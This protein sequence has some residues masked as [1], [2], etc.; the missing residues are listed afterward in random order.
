MSS[1][2]E[3]L[4]TDASISTSVAPCQGK[5]G[6]AIYDAQKS[7]KT[8]DQKS[9]IRQHLVKEASAEVDQEQDLTRKL[10]LKSLIKSSFSYP[11][12]KI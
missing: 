7:T 6:A 11:G 9:H 3:S 10:S 1:I 2:F 5:G 12:S 4:N 8:Y